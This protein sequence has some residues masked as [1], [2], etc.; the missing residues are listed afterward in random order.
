MKT[1]AIFVVFTLLVSVTQAAEFVVVKEGETVSW[2]VL[3]AKP[4]SAENYAAEQLKNY[5]KNISGATLPIVQYSEFIESVPGNFIFIGQSVTNQGISNLCKDKLIH[6]NNAYP[7]R[8]GYIIKN[9]SEKEQNILALAATEDYAVP[10]AVFHLL[11]KVLHTGFFWDGEYVPKQNTIILKDLDIAEDP[12][13]ENRQ[14]MQG[15]ALAYSTRY[16]D[17]CGPRRVPIG[18]NWQREIDWM[19]KKKL[20][21]LDAHDL[22]YDFVWRNV[23]KQFGVPVGELREWDVIQRSLTKQTYSYAHRVGVRTVGPTFIG[24]VPDAFAKK[25]PKTKY[26]KTQWLDMPPQYFVHPSDPLFVETGAAFLRQYN[27]EYG[28]THLYNADP[29]PELNFGESEEEKSATQVA[30][31]WGIVRSIKK[32]D[33][34]WKC[35]MSGWA[36][37]WDKKTWTPNRVKALLDT[38][39]DRM[40]VVND[41]WAERNPIYKKYDY[42]Y[43]KNWGFSVLHAFGGE[44]TLH[45]D[46]AG[47]VRRVNEAIDDPK[48]TRL[49]NFYI[50]PEIVHHNVL[51]YDLAAALAWDPRGIELDSFLSDY[52]LRRYGADSA[53]T[54]TEALWQLAQSVYATND[55]TPPMYQ[56]ALFGGFGKEIRSRAKYIPYLKKA[57]EI[58]LTEKDRQKN[59]PLYANDMVDF[60][61]QYIG[62][63]FNLHIVAL[64]DAFKNNDL[65]TFEKEAKAVQFYLDAQEQLLSSHPDYLLSIEIMRA[66]SFPQRKEKYTNDVD[67]RKRLSVLTGFNSYP[68]LLDYARKDMYELIKWYYRKRVEAYMTHL[69]KNINTPKQIEKDELNKIYRKICER[70]VDNPIPTRAK[71]PYFGKPVVAVQKIFDEIK[72]KE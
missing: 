27:A 15:C 23:C 41:I 53:D 65:E 7:G 66:M 52:A 34:S 25:Y 51:Y 61:R 19:V 37:F 32:A 59:N 35:L 20:N 22:G 5:I 64:W 6:I 72:N 3:G 39:P 33:P 54:M 46:L 24:E 56:L 69:R 36:F 18:G 17:F 12:R 44:T 45:G 57:I 68:K 10:Y 58:A 28:T 63:L 2:I 4:T 71:G 38:F 9:I 11:E 13:F 21:I 40:L 47:L 48:A 42:F 16:W 31:G 14:Y 43:G 62:E 30:Y 50:N 8:G 29:Y 67:V 70:W 55:T 60:T 1:Y 49:T 26:L